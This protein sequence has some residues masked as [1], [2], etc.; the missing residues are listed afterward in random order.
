MRFASFEPKT[1][2]RQRSS[3]AFDVDV[4]VAVAVAVRHCHRPSVKEHKAQL[5]RDSVGLKAPRNYEFHW[6]E[7]QKQQQICQRTVNIVSAC[8]VNA[9]AR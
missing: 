8:I 2:R 9:I 1:V 5:R 3:A 7:K 4:A 6:Y